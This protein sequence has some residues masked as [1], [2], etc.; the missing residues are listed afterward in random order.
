[1]NTLSAVYAEVFTD[2]EYHARKYNR[3]ER[4][5][6]AQ[7]E[8]TLIG[9]G[10]LGSEIADCLAKAGVG[11]VALVDN[12]ELR[13]KNSVRHLVGLNRAMI[14]KV[15]AVNE[16]LILH[17]PFV[18][19]TPHICDI[20]NA[21]INQYCGTESIGI[22]TIADDD[23][24]GFLNEQAVLN[25]RTIFYAR[26]LR[27]GK[28]ARIF[29]VI[30]G[31]DACKNCLALYNRDSDEKFVQIPEDSSSPTI[32]N[33][34]NNPIRPA[35]AADLK[36]IAAITARKVIDHLQHGIDLNNHW[37]WSTEELDGVQRSPNADA[38]LTSNFIGPHP[39]CEFC[40]HEDA[41]A[42][43]ID[44]ETF[45]TMIKECAESK[46]KETGGVLMGFREGKE[47]IVVTRTSGPGPKAIRK[48]DWFER[49]LEHCQAELE[50]TYNELG[51]RGLYV[52]EW[53]YHPTGSNKP[54]TQDLLSLAAISHQSNY[55]TD[56]PIMLIFSNDFSV[57]ASIHPSNR[58]FCFT[59][60]VVLDSIDSKVPS[61][62]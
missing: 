37:I 50:K 46:E 5:T 43:R 30:P 49:D 38:T 21:N 28:A 10:A 12:E 44:D 24:E 19:T 61:N 26:A 59:N 35:S 33:E 27:G 2:Q 3:A 17:N 31:K 39:E 25:A 60:C 23:I 48:S 13:A 62:S 51:K 14:P 55:M 40:K 47:A 4:N 54:S 58:R 32:R 1:M 42:V 57:S 11:R 8:A 36:I 9:C 18:E 15:W 6:L 53:H 45:Q 56:R 29:R 22:S 7:H 16:H 52:G 20:T 34:C 41:T